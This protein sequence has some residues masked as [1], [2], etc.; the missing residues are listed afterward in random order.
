MKRVILLLLVFS[1]SVGIQADYD[2]KPCKLCKGL[3]YRR[4]GDIKVTCFGCKDGRVPVT[5]EEKREIDMQA[6][7]AA[8][9]M[10]HYNMTPEDYVAFTNLIQAAYQQVPNYIDC[11]SCNKT[12]KCSLCGDPNYASPDGFC[13][14]CAGT[15]ICQICN[16]SGHILMG[17]RDNPNMDLLLDRATSLLKYYEER[18]NSKS[19]SGT[20]PQPN[21]EDISN[22]LTQNLPA[23]NSSSDDWLYIVGIIAACFI[24]YKLF[25]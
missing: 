12:G 1:I 20:E 23:N 7:S 3:G 6:A 4:V 8:Y 5:T 19:V 24:G 18:A 15:G 9:F 13:N 14:M 22:N 10:R 25:K 17:Y 11:K 16:G 21:T 2:T